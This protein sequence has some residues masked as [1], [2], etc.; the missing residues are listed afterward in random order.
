MA[1]ARFNVVCPSCEA[2]V[3]IRSEASIGKKVECPKCKYRFTVPEPEGYVEE[4]PKKAKKGKKE[5]SGKKSPILLFALIGVLAV[6]ALGA[7][8]FFLFGGDDGGSSDGTASSSGSS[9]ST[10]SSSGPTESYPEDEGNG[11]GTNP[12]TPPTDTAI[13]PTPRPSGAADPT[14]LLPG[15]A[16]AV[17]HIDFQRLA[18]EADV[19]K[20][21]FFDSYVRSLFKQSLTFEIDNLGTYIHTLVGPQ[22]DPFAVIQSIDPISEAEFLRLKLEPLGGAGSRKAYKIVSN[23]IVNAMSETFTAGTLFEILGLP[24]IETDSAPEKAKRKQTELAVTLYDDYTVLV[25]TPNELTKFLNSLDADGNPPF[26]SKL[27]EA[28][29]PP[30]EPTPDEDQGEGDE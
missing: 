13:K 30:P 29:P 22:R 25:S 6:A 8:G 1:N 20:R 14:N 27:T 24:G 28:P 10:S 21:A 2:N 11:E 19:L 3:S 26:L 4:A 18:S 15:D 16:T 12:D 23:P 5:K 9:S 17:Y 7:G